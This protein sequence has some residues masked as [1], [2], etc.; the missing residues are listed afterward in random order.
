MLSHRVLLFLSEDVVFYCSNGV[1]CESKSF[2]DDLYRTFS[3][4][5]QPDLHQESSIQ[6]CGFLHKLPRNDATLIEIIEQYEGNYIQ[7]LSFYIGRNLTYDTDV[8]NAFSGIINAQSVLLGDFE[9]GMP[10][11]LFARALFL[12]V[13]PQSGPLSRRNGFPSWS[14]IGWKLEVGSPRTVLNDGGYRHFRHRGYW[15]LV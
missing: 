8:L 7:L 2:G 1:A 15:P 11:R 6:N 3:P 10:L 4:M 13:T 9:S 14:W 12:S 5:E